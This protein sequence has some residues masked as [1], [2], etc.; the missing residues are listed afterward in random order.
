MSRKQK[1]FFEVLKC[2]S[3]NCNQVWEWTDGH[4]LWQ[5]PCRQQTEHYA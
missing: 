5:L 4:K 1:K 3:A 2:H